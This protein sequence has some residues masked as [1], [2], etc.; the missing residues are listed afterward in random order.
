M[1]ISTPYTYQQDTY[2]SSIPI[3]HK[4]QKYSGHTDADNTT[5]SAP[6]DQHTHTSM[7]AHIDCHMYHIYILSTTFCKTAPVTV[8]GHTLTHPSLHTHR[9][10]H[11]Q[12]GISRTHRERHIT[13]KLTLTQ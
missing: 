5:S 6:T 11:I 9:S 8:H 3:H 13:H 10:I 1:H 4:T 2:T 7:Q 12:I